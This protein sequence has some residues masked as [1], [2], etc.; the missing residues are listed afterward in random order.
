L[1]FIDKE[2]KENSDDLVGK[3]KGELNRNIV[4]NYAFDNLDKLTKDLNYKKIEVSILNRMIFVT[5]KLAGAGEKKLV[6]KNSLKLFSKSRYNGISIL[7]L[8]FFIG[9]NSNINNWCKKII[10]KIG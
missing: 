9:I 7:F 6:I 1:C 10:S 2:T 3:Y 8:S 4:A 5:A